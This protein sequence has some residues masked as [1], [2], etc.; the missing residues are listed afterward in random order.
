MRKK[1]YVSASVSGSP[2]R[3]IISKGFDTRVEAE[4]FRI[5]EYRENKNKNMNIE[6]M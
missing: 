4:K 1:Y 5:K 3:Q 2:R 6:V